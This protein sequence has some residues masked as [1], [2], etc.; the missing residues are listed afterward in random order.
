[1]FFIYYT[2]TQREKIIK[3]LKLKKKRIK[4]KYKM[5]FSDI[6]NDVKFTGS[7]VEFPGEMVTIMLYLM[8][9]AWLILNFDNDVN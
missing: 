8:M 4:F 3:K 1:M 9:F 6:K 7:A 2:Q 5:N